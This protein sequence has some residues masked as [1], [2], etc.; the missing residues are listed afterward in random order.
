MII[1][2]V[3]DFRYRYRFALKRHNV[4]TFGIYIAAIIAGLLLLIEFWFQNHFPIF[5]FA[6]AYSNLK[7]FVATIFLALI[8]YVVSL[9]YLRPAKFKR[10]NA[11]RF[12]QATFH[13]IHQGNADRLQVVAEEL[14]NSIT[15]VFESASR[16]PGDGSGNQ[17]KLPPEQ[18]FAHYLLLLIADG[19]FCHLIVDRVPGFALLCFELAAKYPNVPFAQFSRNIGEAFITNKGSAFYQEESGFESGLFGYVKPVTTFIFGCYELVEHCASRNA[20]PLDIDYSKLVTFDKI[21]MDGFRRAALAFFSS[22]LQKTKGQIHSFAC[23]RLLHSFRSTTSGTYKLNGASGEFW[24]MPEYQRLEITVDFVRD[25][26]GSLDKHAV[27]PTTL[28]H[29]DR[30]RKD[31]F[32][33]FADLVFD[34]IFAASSVSQPDWTCWSVQHNAVWS[35]LFSFNKSTAS[36]II[37][38]KLRRLIYAEIK[39]MDKFPNFKGARFL[40][41]CLNVFGLTLVDRHK[42]FRRNVYPLQAAVLDWTKRNYRRL[43]TGDPKVAEACLQGA[44]TYDAENHRLVKTF[45][46]ATKKEP[47]CVFLKLD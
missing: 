43:V 9:C 22:Y 8:F 3:S 34:I 1:V 41:Y 35:E 11:E 23:A 5:H 46:N 40:G 21:Q 45:S 30:Y 28:K 36:S 10:S 16:V 38:F 18:E 44:V 37:L 32:D 42:G 31:I 14:S 4:G 15:D 33:D 24:N 13:L 2:T 6:N 20:C 7:I 29:K 39:E 25:A 19:R 27:R 26:I 17:R 47:V 12:F